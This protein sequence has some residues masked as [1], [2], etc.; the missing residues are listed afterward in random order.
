MGTRTHGAKFLS[1]VTSGSAA[2]AL[3]CTE[4][5]L[6]QRASRLLAVFDAVGR[7]QLMIR[8]PM[9]PQGATLFGCG[10]PVTCLGYT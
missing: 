9:Y 5:S 7:S 8:G 2:D 4:T 10:L 3:N 1:S 6:G